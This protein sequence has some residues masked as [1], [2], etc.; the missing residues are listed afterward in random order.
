MQVMIYQGIT[1]SKMKQVKH[2]N[3]CCKA[4]LG[5]REKW[6]L[7]FF[8]NSSERKLVSPVNTELSTVFCYFFL[9]KVLQA[10]LFKGSWGIHRLGETWRKRVLHQSCCRPEG[11]EEAGTCLAFLEKEWHSVDLAKNMEGGT[12]RARLA[13]LARARKAGALSWSRWSL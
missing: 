1:A 9:R 12:V 11:H 6:R 2:R 10:F 8:R 5:A 3:S 4:G 7:L 13:P